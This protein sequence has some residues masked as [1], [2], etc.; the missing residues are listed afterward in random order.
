MWA[1]DFPAGAA[2]ELAPGVAGFEPLAGEG[3]TFVTELRGLEG[4]LNV[5]RDRR[6]PEGRF[7]L[8]PDA[9]AW[10]PLG[11]GRF[12]Y[13]LQVDRDGERGLIGDNDRA[14][15]AGWAAGP[16]RSPTPPP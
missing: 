6:K 11:D 10:Y 8:A 7:T 1:A 16:T 12:T 5:V 15:A 3:I 14:R 9:H 2:A 4:V 13:V